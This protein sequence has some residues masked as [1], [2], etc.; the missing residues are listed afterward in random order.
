M[1]DGLV[2]G[3]S[4]EILDKACVQHREFNIEKFSIEKFKLRSSLKIRAA[5]SST[6]TVQALA[7]AVPWF[8]C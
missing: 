1:E 7:V 5:N 8:P 3:D 2:A 4:A 6:E